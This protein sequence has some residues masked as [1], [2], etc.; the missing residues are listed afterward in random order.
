MIF[1]LLTPPQYFEIGDFYSIIREVF[2]FYVELIRSD[3]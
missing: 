3:D 2:G 1:I